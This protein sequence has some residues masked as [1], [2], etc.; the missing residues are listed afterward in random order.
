MPVSSDFIKG[1]VKPMAK[2]VGWGVEVDKDSKEHTHI[3]ARLPI[4]KD[5]TT[6]KGHPRYYS[7]GGFMD[8]ENDVLENLTVSCTIFKGKKKN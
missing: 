5:V 4:D 7:S 8:V 2:L 3:L 6:A 1:K